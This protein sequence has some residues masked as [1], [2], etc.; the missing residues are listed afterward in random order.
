MTSSLGKNSSSDN[1]LSGANLDLRRFLIQVL[2]ATLY[3]QFLNLLS[4]VVEIVASVITS[5][6]LASRMP[7][8]RGLYQTVLFEKSKRDSKL[9]TAS[10]FADSPPAEKHESDDLDDEPRRQDKEPGGRIERPNPRSQ[11]GEK[12]TVTAAAV[13][14][15][16]QLSGKPDTDRQ[17]D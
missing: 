12:L 13:G 16:D 14:A 15:E 17:D 8:H 9:R 5:N 2:A 3:S 6:P 10:R 1:S 4:M 11:R 7:Q